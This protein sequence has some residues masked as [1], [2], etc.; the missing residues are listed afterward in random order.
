MAVNIPLN[1]TIVNAVLKMRATIF[2]RSSGGTFT[3]VLKSGLACLLS[4]VE[5]GR[6]PGTSAAGRRELA[7]LGTFQWDAEYEWPSEPAPT[8][9]VPNARK[10]VA[11][12]IEVDAFPGQ[13]WNPATQGYWPDYAPGAGILARSRDVIRAL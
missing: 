5:G 6:Q 2:G 4:E 3:V 12:Q 13:R 8:P 7:N 9:A 1:R 11:V 10:E